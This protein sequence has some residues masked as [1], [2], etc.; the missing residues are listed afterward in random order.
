MAGQRPFHCHVKGAQLRKIGRE[1]GALLGHPD[2]K[3]AERGK[4]A[5]RRRIGDKLSQKR[6]RRD[7]LVHQVAE[8][9]GVQEEQPLFTQE[10]RGVRAGNVLDRRM[11]LG[12][13]VGQGR[14]GGLGFLGL[15]GLDR[16]HQQIVELR[17]V[18]R[19]LL[20]ML[21]PR[22]FARKHFGR[23]GGHAEMARGVHQRQ[24]GGQH[25]SCDDRKG[26]AAT[27]VGHVDQQSL[28][29]HRRR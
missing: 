24:D 29:R 26:V 20:G 16:D 1:V 27:G 19:E 5:A 17:E 3:Q 9:L 18:A 10:G 22:E 6:L 4:Q 2:A 12:Q 23:I 11:V 15:R 21:P 25:A 13:S 14:G 8:L 28:E 7:D